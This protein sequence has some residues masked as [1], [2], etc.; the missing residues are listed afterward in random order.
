MRTTTRWLGL[1][2][3]ALLAVVA[4]ACGDSEDASGPPEIVEGRTVC[5]ECGM[6]I[7]EI[8]F[9]AS[10][11]TADGDERRYDDIGGMLAQG[12]RDGILDDAE[13]W[14]HDFESHEVLD[15]PDATFVLSGEVPTPMGWGVVAFGS[16]ADAGALA[17]EIGGTAVSWAELVERSSGDDLDPAQLHHDHDAD[18]ND[19]AETDDDHDMA[20]MAETDDMHTEEGEG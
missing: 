13:I 18:M 7:D 16:A 3:L 4:S 6:I 20:D 5:D 19:V 9:A 12:H 10:V 17:D 14:V 11:R 15:A 2:V 8:R 1:W